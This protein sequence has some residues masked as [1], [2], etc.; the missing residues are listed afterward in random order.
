MVRHDG[1]GPRPS[2]GACAPGASVGPHVRGKRCS[3]FISQQ[4][5]RLDISGHQRV[6]AAHARAS[7]NAGLDPR[8]ATHLLVAN[9]APP[10]MPGACTIEGNTLS[11]EMSPANLAALLDPRSSGTL[12]QLRVRRQMPIQAVT[13]PAPGERRERSVKAATNLVWPVQT[14]ASGATSTSHVAAFAR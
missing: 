2:A 4:R 14:S 9:C 7:T 11:I 8:V 1:G 10:D 12:A 13:R 6:P 3:G 5:R